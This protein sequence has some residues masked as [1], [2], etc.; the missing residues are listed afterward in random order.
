MY[1]AWVA[2]GLAL[3]WPALSPLPELPAL[4]LL[5]RIGYL[6]AQMLVPTIPGVVPD[7]RQH[8]VVHRPRRD[9]TPVAIA[10]R[11]PAATRC[12]ASDR[13]PI[14]WPEPRDRKS[15]VGP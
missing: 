11:R 14:G 9:A 10:D 8:A 1:L 13:P 5:P 12:S 2:S 7:V 3:W 4:E 15:W 6:F